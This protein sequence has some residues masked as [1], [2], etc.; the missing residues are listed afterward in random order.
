[1]TEFNIFEDSPAEPK[2]PAGQ[3][4]EKVMFEQMDIVVAL[5][6]NLN[7]D[8][9]LTIGDLENGIRFYQK[10]TAEACIE[11]GK[12][13]L[14][15]KKMTPHGE[16]IQRI[17]LLD[18]NERLAQKFMQAASKFSKTNSKTVLQKAGSQTKF[19]ELLVLDDVALMTLEAGGE[20]AGLTLDGIEC[21]SVSELRAALRGE[22]SAHQA[23]INAINNAE[24][25]AIDKIKVY[26]KKLREPLLSRQT[27]ALMQVS[28]NA[29]AMSAAGVD[30]LSTQVRELH[31]GGD[32][33]SERMFTLHSCLL[34]I[35]SRL[36]LA[37]NG[38]DEAA[39][40]FN[41]TLPDRPKM[42]LSESMARDY[43][44]AHTGYIETAMLLA[45]K[46]IQGRVD[47]LGRTAGRPRKTK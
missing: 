17:E 29:E 3:D 47:V 43:L 27:D 33:L 46:A 41:I 5:A 18:F 4:K 16:F 14:L 40:A 12:R 36:V 1:M 44:S 26:E 37:L 38:L 25:T 21:M 19:L 30:H 42:A 45:N 39:E 34:A 11:L 2:L 22:R 23:Q 9:E 10:R 8:G 15:L 6:K 32:H 28:L 35:N 24:N 7:Y 20:V 13:L 31:Q